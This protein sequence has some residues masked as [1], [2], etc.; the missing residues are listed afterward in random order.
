MFSL[1]RYDSPLMRFLT[2]IFDLLVLNILW[3]VGCIP[4]VTIGA[5]TTAMYCVMLKLAK[6]EEY[7]VFLPFGK[8]F[9]DNFK[10]ATLIWLIFLAAFALVGINLFLCFF[11]VLDGTF[12]KL[13]VLIISGLLAIPVFFAFLYALPLQARFYNPIKQTLQNALLISL[14][15][16]PATIL[17]VLLDAAVIWVT[18]F[19]VPFL[20]VFTGILVAFVNAWFLSRIFAQY[21]KKEEM[22]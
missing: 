9:R 14:T 12:L 15:H 16:L 10:Q 8:A 18:V 19:A 5:S 21:M 11:G 2:G 6:G 17:M 20:S 1:F 7:E 22:L 13:I 3:L 4:V